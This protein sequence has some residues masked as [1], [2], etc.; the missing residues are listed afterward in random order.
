[1]RRWAWR[2]PCDGASHL[3]PGVASD[4]LVES[5]TLAIKQITGEDM[6]PPV[7]PWWAFRDPLIVAVMQV[8]SRQA[9]EM[10]PGPMSLRLVDAV[11]YYQRCYEAAV[12]A[13]REAESKPP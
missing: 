12:S 8:R 11:A 5:V 6:P 10:A 1:M 13:R 7:C 3:L 9:G 4:H 2:C